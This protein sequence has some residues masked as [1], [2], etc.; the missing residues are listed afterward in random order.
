VSSWKAVSR[1][2]LHRAQ[3]AAQFGQSLQAPDTGITGRYG[4]VQIIEHAVAMIG[5]EGDFGVLATLA[6]LLHQCSDNAD[7]IDIAIQM[8][9]FEKRA[10]RLASGRAQMHEVNAWTE[11][12]CHGHKVVI[13]THT[14]RTRAETHAIG[15]HRHGIKQCLIIGS[16]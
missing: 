5:T 11:M 13:G 3:D 16:G 14:Q 9:R 4:L 1:Q 6:V 10:V 7:H 8:I 2:A 12:P 15:F